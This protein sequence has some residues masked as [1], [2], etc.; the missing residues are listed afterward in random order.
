MLTCGL[1]VSD[2]PDGNW[3]SFAV[4]VGTPPVNVRT[5]VS[6]LTPETWVILPQ[7]CGKNS[8]NDCSNNRGGVFNPLASKSWQDQ[9]TWSLSAEL[10]LGYDANNGGNYGYDT[11]GV[12]T[13]TGDVSLDHQV[14]A[15]ITTNDFYLGYLGLATRTPGFN[16]QSQPPFLVSL[17]DA[18]RI[19]SLSYSYTAGAHY[20]KR[21][22]S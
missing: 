17:R 11:L 1:R 10:N 19:P 20:S 4:R 8:A 21:D 16:N 7:G 2:G 12:A 14:V 9:R 18:K 13:T 5:L 15:G 22:Q 3:S 6:T